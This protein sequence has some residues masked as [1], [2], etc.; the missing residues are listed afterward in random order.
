MLKKK[1]INVYFAL[2]SQRRS[3]N[4]FSGRKHKKVITVITSGHRSQQLDFFLEKEIQLPLF[5]L[6]LFCLYSHFTPW[7]WNGSIPIFPLH[8]Y[9]LKILCRI[10]APICFSS[11]TAPAFRSS[12]LSLYGFHAEFV[13]CTFVRRKSFYGDGWWNCVL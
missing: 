1:W 10:A 13:S 7:K 8:I 4:G 6:L 2:T 11:E 9:V 3:G 5:T 12:D